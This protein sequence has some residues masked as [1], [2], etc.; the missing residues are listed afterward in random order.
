MMTLVGLSQCLIG[1]L[2]PI[3]ADDISRPKQ[4][5]LEAKSQVWQEPLRSR[6]YSSLAVGHFVH[7]FHFVDCPGGTGIF[8]SEAIAHKHCI[9]SIMRCW[10]VG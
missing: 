5:G 6:S 2:P 4:V 8:E 9:Y 7:D 10:L 1:G 3:A